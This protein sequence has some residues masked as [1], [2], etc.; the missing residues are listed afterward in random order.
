[1]SQIIQERLFAG[2]S[3]ACDRIA[4]FKQLEKVK[5]LSKKVH[6]IELD[7]RATFQIFGEDAEL[8]LFDDAAHLAVS[9][10][11]SGVMESTRWWYGSMIRTAATTIQSGFRGMTARKIARIKR[12]GLN[13][14]R[15]Y[16]KRV[17][18]QTRFELWHENAK[19]QK[20]TQRRPIGAGLVLRWCWL[21]LV[22]VLGW[23]WLVLAGAG[24]VP[25]G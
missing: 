14:G 6:D 5:S 16:V 15:R 25:A 2:S 9:Q 4:T 18:L 19:T 12:K 22:L 7:A 24:L 10:T 11:V 8:K 23:C 17:A 3:K 13:A 20:K 21:V 1:M